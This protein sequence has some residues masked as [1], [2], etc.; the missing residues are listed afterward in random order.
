MK[1]EKFEQQCDDGIDITSALDM[2]KAKR[3]LKQMPANAAAAFDLL[4]SFPTDFMADGRQDPAPQER[5][6][7]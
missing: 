5:E 4:S 1:A 7:F 2:S 3:V 6:A